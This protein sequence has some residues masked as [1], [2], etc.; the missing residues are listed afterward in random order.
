MENA[1]LKNKREGLPYIKSLTEILFEICLRGFCPK[2]DSFMGWF[3]GF[4]SYI[5]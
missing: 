1:L 5:F 4:Y 3:F 2:A